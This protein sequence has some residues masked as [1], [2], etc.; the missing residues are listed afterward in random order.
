MIAGG[1]PP[2][3]GM[4]PMPLQYFVAQISQFQECGPTDMN[5]E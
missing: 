5:D 4:V 1:V 2:T 3:T